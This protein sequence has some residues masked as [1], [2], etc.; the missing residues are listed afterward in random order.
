MLK[1]AQPGSYIHPLCQNT[2]ALV[3]AG[4]QGTRLGGLTRARAKPATPFGGS[5]RII[6]F[7]LSNCMNSGIR[8]IGVLTQ[9]NATALLQHI[10]R[11]WGFVRSEFGEWVASLPA[12]TGQGHGW[13]EGTANAVWQNINMLYNLNADYCIIAAGD[14]VYAMNY[15][16]LLEQHV[17]TGADITLACVPV[18]ARHAHQFGLIEC[19]EHNRISLFIEKPADPTPYLNQQN[20]ALASMGIYVFN[21]DALVELLERDNL[22]LESEHDFGH[23]ILPLA[24]EEGADVRGWLF[25]QTNGSS[26]GYWRDVGTIE[27]YYDASMDLLAPLPKLNLYNPR[28][29]IWTCAEPLPPA[30]LSRDSNGSKTQIQDSLLT[31]GSTLIGTQM[32]QSVCSHNV[33]INSGSEIDSSIILPEVVI[34]RRCR[35]RNAIIDEGCQLPTGLVVGEDDKED[36]VRFALADNGIVLVTREHLALL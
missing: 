11:S 27:S 33:T 26:P 36:A 20:E 9:H 31:N 16:P 21:R 22:L 1:I 32:S 35:I 6:D 23:S 30:K 13:Y 8:R 15:L 18:P 5:Y 34:G 19:D 25:N 3:L 24:L 28:W 2:C 29:R 10:Q 12:Q 7:A 14:H 4:G 17:E